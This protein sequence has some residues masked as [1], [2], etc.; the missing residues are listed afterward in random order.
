VKSSTE[1]VQ[2]LPA[3][4]AFVVQVAVEADVARGYWVGRV[5]HVVSGEARHFQTLDDLLGFMAQVLRSASP[6]RPETP[7]NDSA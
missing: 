5:E 3:R 1:D 2:R 7:G 6:L 4:Q